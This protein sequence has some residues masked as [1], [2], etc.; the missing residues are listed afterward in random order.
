MNQERPGVQAGFG[1]GRG[2]RDRIASIHWIIEKAREFQKSIYFCFIDYAKAFVWIT[3]NYGKFLK[4]WEY[5][6]TL[7]ASWETCMQVKKQQLELDTEQWTGSELWKES[8]Q[9]V[10]S[11]CLFNLYAVCVMQH[12]GLN[13]SQAGG[14]AARR[15]INNQYVDDTTLMVESKEELKTLLRKWKTRVQ[16]LA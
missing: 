6:I 14:K 5:Q 8:V 16:N 2:T 10:L 13:D 7:L 1:K 11:P 9:G 12:A 15:N 4:R 3:T